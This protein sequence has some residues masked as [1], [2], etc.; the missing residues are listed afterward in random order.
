M[1]KLFFCL[2]LLGAA[3]SFASAQ[4][5]VIVHPDAPLESLNPSELEDIL[6]GK[7][8]QWGTGQ[9]IEIATLKDGAAHNAF[10]KTYAKRTPSQFK[11]FWRNQ[12]FSGRGTMPKEFPNA[13]AMLSYVAATPNAIGYV[14][15]E[16]VDASVKVITVS[17]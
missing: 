2:A 6:L 5:A 15:A 17:P 11:T 13:S 10:C 14:D 4:V 1:K 9:V 7:K 16:A 8:T 12:V 3:V